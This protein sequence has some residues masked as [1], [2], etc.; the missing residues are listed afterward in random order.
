MNGDCSIHVAQICVA[1]ILPVLSTGVFVARNVLHTKRK[2]Q[3]IVITK[4]RSIQIGP[5]HSRGI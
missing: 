4:S 3:N 1:Q 2:T 5:F